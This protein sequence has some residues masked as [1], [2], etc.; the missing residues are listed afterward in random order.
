MLV[1]VSQGWHGAAEGYRQ[2]RVQGKIVSRWIGR[3][4]YAFAL[5]IP[6][7]LRESAHRVED[8]LDI[9]GYRIVRTLG[10]GGM[11]T[12][13]LAEQESVQREVALKVMSAVLLGDD[14][15]GERFLREARIAAKLRH[16]NVVQVHDVGICGEHHY[17]AMEYL[18]G[19]QVMDRSGTPR[20]VE[21][22]LS[23]A[24]QIA[25]A[26]DYAGA[27]GIVHRDIKPDNILLREDGTAVLTDFGIARASDASR[28][29][30]T[31]AIVGTPHYMSPEQA[32]GQALD[33]RADLYSLG[34]VLYEMLV[35]RVPY[36]AADSLAVGIMH[37]TAPLPKLPDEFAWLQPVLDRML[38]KDPAQRY[39]NGAEAVAALNAARRTPGISRETRVLPVVTVTPVPPAPTSPAPL[40]EWEESDEPRLGRIEEVLHTPTRMRVAGSAARAGGRWRWFTAAVVILALAGTA[41]YVFQ[42]RL[43]EHLPQTRMNSLLLDADQALR[44][45]RL[46]GSEGSARELYLTAL[47]LDPD[48]L[49]AQRGLQETGRQLLVRARDALAQ[50][51]AAP[52]T[53]LLAQAQSLSLPA[54]DVA[55]L[56]RALQVR[57]SR[58]VELG[59]LLDAARAAANDGLLDGDADSAVALYRRVLA[60]DAGNAIAAAGLRDVL[61]RVLDQAGEAISATQF[62]AASQIIERVAALDSSHLGLPE[63]R[64]ALAQARQTQAND[65]DTQLAAADALLAGGQLTPPRQPNALQGYRAV[66]ALDPTQPRA[67]EGVRKVAD[68]LLVQAG[69]RIDDHQ[70]DAASDLIEQ[71]RA[72][73]PNL[74]ALATTQRRFDDVRERRDRV[75]A[76]QVAAAIDI[77][78]TLQRARDAA[79]AGQFLMPPGESAYDLYR[80]VLA[81]ASG[82]A[83]ARAGLAGLPDRAMRRFEDA[84]A[85]NRLS[86]ARDALEAM[87]VIAPSDT[88]LAAARQ[89]LAR[90]YLAYASERLGAGEID[91]ATRAFNQARELDP[92][93]T[94]LPSI[95]ARL[96]QARGG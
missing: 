34:I 69:R 59:S 25:S 52:A 81:R 86:T 51:D 55:E 16:P 32:R 79:Q 12:V 15:F 45:G 14:Q 62:D 56:A 38:A 96:E 4:W 89:R 37:I 48:H 33:G 26:L 85:G 2:P 78:A 18:P 63:A 90:S 47:A 23:V 1:V 21:F 53:A 82:N 95:Q 46:S 35:G 77:P 29:T 92:A 9:S 30:R 41:A 8:E 13:Y 50:G 65:L 54:A 22:S 17:I 7:G 74:P 58:D 43:R 28:M 5:A 73:A 83:E 24:G 40:S 19:G 66:L 6:C 67:L 87:S 71:A 68:A 72:L 61:A 80:A 64:A 94:E 20:S 57:E 70:F 11:A 31:G 93:N 36:Q 27:R 75:E 42:D 44:E 39:Q 76:Q 3:S 84:M 88:R 60:L 91:L 49:P 10:R